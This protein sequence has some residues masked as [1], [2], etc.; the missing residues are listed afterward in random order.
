MASPTQW[1]T[2]LGVGV[3]DGS[4]GLVGD[5]RVPGA[6]GHAEQVQEEGADRKQ[7]GC[8]SPGQV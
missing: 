2:P 4:E 8:H 3:P 7:V 6:L 1:T 5:Y